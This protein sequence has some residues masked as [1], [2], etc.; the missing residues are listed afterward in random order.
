MSKRIDLI[1]DRKVNF[2]PG[3]ERQLLNTYLEYKGNI[4]VFIRSRPILRIDYK[5]YGGT[6]ETFERI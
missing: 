6:P 4:R 5:A 3:Y 2:F 1:E